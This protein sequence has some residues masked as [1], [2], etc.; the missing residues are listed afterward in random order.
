MKKLMFFLLAV[1]SV[2]GFSCKRTDEVNPVLQTV[3]H[4]GDSLKIQDLPIKPSV[5]AGAYNLSGSANGTGSTAR[6]NHP[7]GIFTKSDGSLLVADHDNRAIRNIS[8]A[9]VVTTPYHTD[10]SPTDVA[11]IA[12]GAV[13]VVSDGQVVVFNHGTHITRV[14]IPNPFTRSNVAGI[15]KNPGSTFFLYGLNTGLVFS[16]Y[17]VS[18]NET[19]A[20]PL[21]SIPISDQSRGGSAIPIASFSVAANDNKFL[22]TR[23]EIFECTHGGVVFS[24]LPGFTFLRSIIANH[25]GTKLYV[26]DKGAIKRIT[27]CSTCKPVLTTLLSNTDADGLALSNDERVLY[28]TSVAHNTVNRVDLP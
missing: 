9:N 18:I 15:D 2:A 3:D 10:E 7:L 19:S 22:A 13:G 11:A 28:F 6:F 26:S 14:L 21:P 8:T 1:V 25:D 4:P 23:T 20:S 12:D 27:R 16:S 24:I 17:L 5:I